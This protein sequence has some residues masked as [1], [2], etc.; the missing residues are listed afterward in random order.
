[1]LGIHLDKSGDPEE[2]FL[3]GKL[4]KM[5]AVVSW[6]P[7]LMSKLE[8]NRQRYSFSDKNLLSL[9]WCYVKPNRDRPLG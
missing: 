9:F 2:F 4:C 6:Q 8:E 7:A 1:M 3:S 5:G